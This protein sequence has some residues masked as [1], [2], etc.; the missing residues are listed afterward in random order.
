MSL[1]IDFLLASRLIVDFW[2]KQT[3]VGSLWGVIVIL[4]YIGSKLYTLRFNFLDY[5]ILTFFLI[6]IFSSTFNPYLAEETIKST[7]KYFVPMMIGSLAADYEYVPSKYLEIFFVL[8]AFASIFYVYHVYKTV[9]FGLIAVG[10]EKNDLFTSI[11]GFSQGLLKVL[12]VSFFFSRLYPGFK[13]RRLLVFIITPLIFLLQVRSTIFALL[14]VLPFIYEFKSKWEKYVTLSF[15]VILFGFMFKIF[16]ALM[17]RFR[18]N[19]QLTLNAFSA[20]RLG[21]WNAYFQTMNPLEWLVGKGSSFFAS[22]RLLLRLGLHNDFFQF[23][24]S[25]GIVAS[26]IIVVLFIV[27]F[28]KLHLPFRELAALAVPIMVLSMTNGTLFHQNTALLYVVIGVLLRKA[29]NKRRAEASASQIVP[30]Y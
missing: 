23:I 14:L 18:G 8:F 16:Y 5:L 27:L 29:Q 9:G 7:L 25:Y 12:I 2:S 1:I 15:V 11:H 10:Q 19:G 30:A 28:F 4:I 24:F 13:N 22:K 21:I 17:T 3:S 26:A 20:G 6:S